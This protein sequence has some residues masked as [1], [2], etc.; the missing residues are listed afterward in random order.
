MLLKRKGDLE[1]MALAKDPSTQAVP[2]EVAPLPPQQP[3]PIVQSPE[4]TSGSQK[5]PVIQRVQL[6]EHPTS[7][8][9]VVS[10]VTSLREAPAKLDDSEEFT[11]TSWLNEVFM[12]AVRLNAS[13]IHII[14]E[15]DYTSVRFR[16]DGIINEVAKWDIDYHEMVISRIK[17]ISG[18]QVV[19]KNVPQDGHLELLFEQS[20]TAAPGTASLNF[21]VSTMPTINGEAAVLRVLSKE[22][23][24]LNLEQVGL[25]DKAL[26]TLRKILQRG[27]GVILM[28][29]YSGSGKTTTMYAAM[30]EIDAAQKVII[31]LEDPVEYRVPMVQQSQVNPLVGYHFDTGL[32]AILR[33]DPD[34]IM[35]GEI[36]DDETANIAMRLAMVGRLVLTT[37]HTNSISG[38]L[39]RVMDM[40]ISK[41]VISTAFMGVVA[42]RLVRKICPACR[43]EAA[44]PYELMNMFGIEWPSDQKVY[45]GRG[46]DACGHTG[47]V[48]RIGIFEILEID[49][50]FIDIMLKDNQAAALEEHVRGHVV[51]TLRDDGFDKVRRG[52]TT[53]EEVIRATI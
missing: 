40:G 6:P 17:I 50:A 7:Q 15:R 41:S 10:K 2:P 38:A 36:R 47:F 23:S 37:I 20:K 16:V 12:E 3:T 11:P 35:I 53:L 44:P 46:C 33:Q 28:T 31:T 48:D 49:P 45:A 4:F 14:P 21:R 25:S 42:E 29:G 9:P 26:F 22:S 24:V 13:D 19:E 51:E 18:L 30:N 32:K 27:H 43:Q 39:T 1:T 52:I 34:V 5:P 8:A